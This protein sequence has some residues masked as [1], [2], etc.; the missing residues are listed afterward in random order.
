V[1]VYIDVHRDVLLLLRLLFLVVLVAFVLRDTLLLLLLLLLCC[2]CCCC[3]CCFFF[4]GGCCCCCICWSWSGVSFWGERGA[5]GALG[6]DGGGPRGTSASG[7][8]LSS[9]AG[10]SVV[11][12]AG[13]GSSGVDFTLDEDGRLPFTL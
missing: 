2:C 7:R 8:F 4:I 11:G 10:A 1:T 13:N 9:K 12:T 3:C 6:N 5:D